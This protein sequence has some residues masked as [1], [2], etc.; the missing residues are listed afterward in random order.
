MPHVP[1]ID[2]QPSLNDIYHGMSDESHTLD[3]S[4]VEVD[5][6]TLGMLIIGMC[7]FYLHEMIYAQT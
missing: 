4:E 7:S 1:A 2:K 5:F 3:R 6:C